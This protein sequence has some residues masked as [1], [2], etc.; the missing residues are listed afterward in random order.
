M[1]LVSDRYL[2]VEALTT[3]FPLRRRRNGGRG[4]VY[5]RAVDEVSLWVARGEVLGLVGES[6]CGKSTLARSIMQ[7]VPVTSGRVAL[8]GRTLTSLSRRALRAARVEFQMI[9]QDPYSSLNPRMTVFDTLAEALRRRQAL[10]GAALR[11][12][13]RCS[14]TSKM[15]TLGR[16]LMNSQNH[17]KNQ[18]KDPIRNPNSVNVGK[19]EPHE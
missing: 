4:E 7:L 10:R 8:A 3:H 17:M 14:L 9:F 13:G 1:T 19:Y 5:V 12:A 16:N 6:G 18:Q 15:D 11:G 2:V